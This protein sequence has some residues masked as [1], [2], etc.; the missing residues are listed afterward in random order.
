MEEKKDIYSLDRTFGQAMT[1]KE[2]DDYQNDYSGY[3]FE[4][5]L[6]IAYYLTSVA[7]NFDRN[8]P[9]HLDKARQSY[10]RCRKT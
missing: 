5:R 9:P 2:A 10:F 1:A 8:N 6:S 3:A 4:S 7:Y